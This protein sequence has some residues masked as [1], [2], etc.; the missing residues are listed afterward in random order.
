VRKGAFFA[1][2]NTVIFLLLFTLTLS[3]CTSMG[4]NDE[5]LPAAP[6]GTFPTLS[7][8][9]EDGDP[10][11][12]VTIDI[13][14][15]GVNEDVKLYNTERDGETPYISAVVDGEERRA[16]VQPRYWDGFCRIGWS[17]ADGDGVNELLL[18]FGTDAGQ[19]ISILKWDSANK[20]F[21]SLPTP[22]NGFEGDWYGGYGLPS[23]ENRTLGAINRAVTEDGA[24]KIY[25]P[26]DGGSLVTT[27]V[28]DEASYTIKNQ[29]TVES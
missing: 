21:I 26:C 20:I 11:A 17:D 4:M 15:D 7:R 6:S 25:Q 22:K 29:L 24:I 14:G 3:A 13:T 5:T 12:S 27:F 8:E 23:D 2:K 1:V 10:A 9:S 28:A 19:L 16:A 18:T